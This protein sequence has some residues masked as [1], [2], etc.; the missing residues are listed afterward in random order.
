MTD[1]MCHRDRGLKDSEH[2]AKLD[3]EH[4]GRRGR[5]AR[6]QGLDPSL[7]GVEEERESAWRSRGR[8][9]A[10]QI[11]QCPDRSRQFFLAK[12]ESPAGIG[13]GIFPLRGHHT[14]AHTL[15]GQEGEASGWGR[16]RLGGGLGTRAGCG[17]R[18]RTRR[19]RHLAP[20]PV[21]HRLAARPPLALPWGLRGARPPQRPGL[22]T[23]SS[24]TAA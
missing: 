12:V 11:G 3:F 19:P 13:L 4:T 15:L 23:S 10:G 18:G 8:G 6:A 14:T 20:G 24:S 21:Q 16:D 5:G 7:A 1:M 22:S 2:R 9:G 17:D